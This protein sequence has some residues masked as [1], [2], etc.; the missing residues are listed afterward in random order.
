MATTVTSNSASE[1]I[2]PRVNGSAGTLDE[3][4]IDAITV[5]KQIANGNS[6]T[7]A[8][9]NPMSIHEHVPNKARMA[10]TRPEH[11]PRTVFAGKV[12]TCTH[13]W[14]VGRIDSMV[15]HEILLKLF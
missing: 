6:L 10:R 3:P 1:Y 13:E 9:H 7:N 8:H 11:G 14:G 2:A 4:L 15:V 5:Q 12:R